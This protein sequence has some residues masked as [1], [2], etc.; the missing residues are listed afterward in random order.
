MTSRFEDFIYPGKLYNYLEGPSIRFEDEWKDAMALTFCYCSST[1]LT[2]WHPIFSVFFHLKFMGWFQSRYE[3]CPFAAIQTD[4][5]CKIFPIYNAWGDFVLCISSAIQKRINF[6][7]LYAFN[8]VPNFAWL[9]PF[10]TH[11]EILKSVWVWFLFM[12]K[13]I[14]ISFTACWLTFS[15]CKLVCLS[16]KWAC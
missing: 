3:L 7:T 11:K 2:E 4:T 14:Y 8:S 16:L 9:L 12:L 5:S 13:Y 6:P 10:M 15:K 1:L